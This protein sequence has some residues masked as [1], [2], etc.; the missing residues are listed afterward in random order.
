MKT[1]FKV[2]VGLLCATT[3][4]SSIYAVRQRQWALHLRDQLSETNKDDVKLMQSLSTTELEN[5]CARFRAAGEIR[6][7]DWITGQYLA[8]REDVAKAGSG[9]DEVQGELQ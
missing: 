5:L 7:A 6:I 8:P 2:T 9:S 3:L 1:R 4:L